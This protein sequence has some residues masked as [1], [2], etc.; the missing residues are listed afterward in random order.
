M[1]GDFL[2]RYGFVEEGETLLR[3]GLELARG[4]RFKFPLVAALEGLAEA[5]L[6]SGELDAAEAS[7]TPFLTP[8]GERRRPGSRKYSYRQLCGAPEPNSGCRLRTLAGTCGPA[9]RPLKA[10]GPT[11]QA[12]LRTWRRS[13]GGWRPSV[14]YRFRATGTEGQPAVRMISARS[15]LS[16]LL[17]SPV[18]T[19]V[20]LWR[21]Q[22][23]MS[24]R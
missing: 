5:A 22:V 20:P 15:V 14:S 6:A 3:E 7:E 1:Y 4:Y 11:A 23:A 13:P 21:A 8:P 17:K 2:V 16:S 12:L 18:T 10:F 19:E 24:G 9:R